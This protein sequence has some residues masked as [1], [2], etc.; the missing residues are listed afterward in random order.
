VNAGSFDILYTGGVWVH[1]S[2]QY[3]FEAAFLPDFANNQ[4]VFDQYR[5]NWVEIDFV[6]GQNVVSAPEDSALTSGTGCL[7]VLLIATD[8][9]GASATPT[10]EAMMMRYSNHRKVLLNKPYRHR[11]VPRVSTQMY[12]S[13]V[14]TIFTGYGLGP[15][16]SWIDSA[17]SHVSHY[18]AVWYMDP[19]GT[20]PGATVTTNTYIKVY[21]RASLSYR[22]GV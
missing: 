14:A 8:L 11:F 21:F 18:G 1:N 12:D 10:T 7:P 20:Y 2:V 5:V 4:T 13:T 22:Q 9:D 17:S 6:P 16:G 15:A 3:S 19:G